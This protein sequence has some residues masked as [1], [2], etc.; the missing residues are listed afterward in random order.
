MTAWN[1]S[2]I[3]G[4]SAQSTFENAINAKGRQNDSLQQSEFE[5]FI[6]ISYRIADIPIHNG[7]GEQTTRVIHKLIGD[8]S[9]VVWHE[10]DQSLV[11]RA[12]RKQHNALAG[13][14][15]QIRRS[16]SDAT[17]QMT[18][19]PIPSSSPNLALAPVPSGPNPYRPLVEHPTPVRPETAV[20]AEC[21][22]C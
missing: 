19:D 7:D 16:V 12:S 15:Q 8:S 13:L 2:E 21:R 5:D 10:K 14:F 17:T 20:R 6:L 3:V 9:S 11:V 4:A 18:P 22:R 1:T